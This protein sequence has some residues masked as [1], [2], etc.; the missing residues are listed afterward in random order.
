[1]IERKNFPF[2]A[3]L[4]ERKRM[5]CEL[6]SSMIVHSEMSSYEDMLDSIGDP[7]KLIS[8]GSISL[9][10]VNRCVEAIEKKYSHQGM[11]LLIDSVIDSV[12]GSFKDENFEFFA[13]SI[14]EHKGMISE[15]QFDRGAIQ[16]VDS[17]LRSKLDGLKQVCTDLDRIYQNIHETFCQIYFETSSF[18]GGSRPS[19]KAVGVVGPVVFSWGGSPMGDAMADTVID[20]SKQVQLVNTC[21]HYVL[22][23]LRRVEAFHRLVMTSFYGIYQLFAE[24]SDHFNE[25]EYGL[26][27]D[28]QNI[29]NKTDEVFSSYY[30]LEI[31]MMHETYTL[32]ISD[33]NNITFKEMVE[34]VHEM[35]PLYGKENK[36]A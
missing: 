8:D 26:Y 24:V 15:H 29:C 6:Y 17:L 9:H 14:P 31:E 11:M 13:K 33:D 22:D 19:S 36:A 5:F 30:N 3:L 18:K 23:Y 21:M 1:M 35:V 2:N 27:L 7:Q 34:R 10:T 25:L 16:M 20:R 12:I 28:L 32:K 4:E